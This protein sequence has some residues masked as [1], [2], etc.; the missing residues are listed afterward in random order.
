MTSSPQVLEHRSSRQG[1]WLEVH[2]L[3][4]TIWIAVAEGLLTIVHVIPKWFVFALAVIAVAVWW[5]AG[6]RSNSHTVRQVSWIFAA[7]Q[8]LVVLVPVLLIVLGTLAVVAV[9]VIAIAGL[10]LLFTERP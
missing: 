1:R 2:R 7:S 10:I 6:R 4:I 5:F 3:R 8:A 9:A